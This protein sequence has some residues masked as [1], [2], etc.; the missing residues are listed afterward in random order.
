M[1]FT[2]NGGGGVE[3][4]MENYECRIKTLIYELRTTNYEV[5]T[6]LG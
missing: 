3:L 2:F 6:I 5:A 4:K 1:K